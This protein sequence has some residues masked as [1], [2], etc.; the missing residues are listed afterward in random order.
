MRSRWSCVVAGTALALVACAGS[1]QPSM[2]SSTLDPPGRAFTARVERVV[3]GDTFIAVR[4][5]ER[6]RVRLIGVD[7]PESVKPG[8]PV[9]CWGPESSRLLHRL[10][11]V[12][13][14]V[15]GAYQDGGKHDIYG[16]DLWDVWLPDGRFLQA[17]LVRK[18]A[19][20]RGGLPA[21][22]RARRPARAA[23]RGGHRSRSRAARRL[24]T[25][26]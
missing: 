5:G 17:V 23:G 22:G 13:S 8:A 11:P 14:V 6:L 9:E 24:L 26:G 10:L 2:A 20:R 25:G 19:R 1:A 7:A 4:R 16:R 18:G 3:D 15:T 12:D 21:A